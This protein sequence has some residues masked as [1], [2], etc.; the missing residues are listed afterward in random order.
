MTEFKV[1]AGRC[2]FCHRTANDV[3]HHVDSVREGEVSRDT[4]A[5]ALHERLFSG[6]ARNARL[7]GGAN[8]AHA[9]D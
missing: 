5:A 4:A 9:A 6:G 1:S 8:S 2:Q 3:G 7:L